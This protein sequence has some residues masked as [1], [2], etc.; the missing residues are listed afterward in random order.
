MK[1]EILYTTK[2]KH[3]KPVA[4]KMA[5]WVKTHAKSIEEYD[6]NSVVDLLVLCFD[7]SFFKDKE[8]CAFIQSLQRSSI[9]NMALVSG[10]YLNDKKMKAM[11]ALCQQTDLP[12]M[13]EQYSW[14]MTY[15]QLKMVDPCVNDGACLYIE[16]MVNIIRDYY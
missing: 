13:R 7:D 14:K 3:V 2:S 15:K 4:T 1:I 6:N 11:I 5:T 16:D 12:L 10:F 9:K 8:L